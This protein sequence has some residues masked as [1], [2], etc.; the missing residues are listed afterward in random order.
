L[1][2]STAR[3]TTDGRPT[4]NRGFCGIPL[5]F[6]TSSG[7]ESEPGGDSRPPVSSAP[8]AAPL[9]HCVQGLTPTT[10]AEA[11]RR[12]PTTVP[13]AGGP[14]NPC[15]VGRSD[16]ASGST[17]PSDGR[18]GIWMSGRTEP[19]TSHPEGNAAR[20]VSKPCRGL[21]KRPGVV[22]RGHRNVPRKQ[23]RC[24]IRTIR[25]RP[26]THGRIW[27]TVPENLPVPAK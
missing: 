22:K 14:S 2:P 1:L 7:P 17:G 10:G 5:L 21:N 23:A 18:P 9:K 19:C 12:R 13:T 8:P 11:G 27:N 20:Q 24:L 16:G 3:A 25:R 6:R 26:P 15:L 4:G